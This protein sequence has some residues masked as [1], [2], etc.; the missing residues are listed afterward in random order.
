VAD[1]YAACLQADICV[2]I[3]LP[4]TS[5]DAIASSF[6]WEHIVPEQKPRALEEFRRVLR[7]GGR[8]VFLYDVECDSPIY[9]RMRRADPALYREILIDREGHLGWES[10][11]ENARLFRE[12]GF[13]LL[14]EQG[15][16]KLLLGPAMYD[17]VQ[18]WGG[19][20]ARLSRVGLR[21]RSG[22]LFHLYNVLNRGFD[23]TVGRWLP[24][25]WSRVV[26]A[27]WEKR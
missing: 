22:P 20:L 10:P 2:R 12:N 8:L 3:P 5:V 9:R 21:F 19:G 7:P 16:E 14:S 4:D 17:K 13:R 18:H 24:H 27:A 15:K 23:E 26:V 1:L 6:V 25:S 11:E